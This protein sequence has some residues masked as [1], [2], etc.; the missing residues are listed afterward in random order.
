MVLLKGLK[1]CPKCVIPKN[2][3]LKTSKG[4]SVNTHLMLEFID[5]CFLQ[6]KSLFGRKNSL[7]L[8]DN[9]GSHK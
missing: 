8:V 2:I 5:E 7:L 3:V 4:G 6:K 9:C 1:K